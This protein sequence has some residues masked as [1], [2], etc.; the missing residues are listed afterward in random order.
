L[1]KYVFALL[2]FL[3][4]KRIQFGIVGFIIGYLLDTAAESRRSSTQS[5]GDPFDFYRRQSS[6]N[7]FQTMLMA[8]SAAVMKADGKVLKVEL[9]FVKQFFAQQFGRHFRQEHLQTLK[10]FLD[11]PTLPLNQICSDINARLQYEARVQLIHYLFHIAKSDGD[12]ATSELQVI[13]QIAR[14][15]GVSTTDFES[16]KNMFYRNVDSDYKILGVEASASDDEIKKAYR[17]MAIKFHPDKV[18]QLG[19]EHQKA[20]KEKFQ[21]IQDAYEALKKRRG[22]K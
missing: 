3:L 6:I 11:A 22:F 5:S 8:L 2:A 16:V 19:E 21:Q 12:V 17:K 10:K 14:N 18:A 20:A 13:D 9:N 7:D 1:Y 4:T 15:L